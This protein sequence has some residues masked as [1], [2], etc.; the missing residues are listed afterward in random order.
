V[1]SKPEIII[2]GCTLRAGHIIICREQITDISL[3]LGAVIA[4]AMMSKL[5]LETN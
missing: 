2:K 3:V 4:N 5:Y 1:L